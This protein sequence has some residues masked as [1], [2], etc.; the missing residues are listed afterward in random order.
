VSDEQ[1]DHSEIGPQAIER[2]EQLSARVEEDR[3]DLLEAKE[4]AGAALVARIGELLDRLRN[5]IKK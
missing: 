2:I 5:E 3:R 4:D 1:A